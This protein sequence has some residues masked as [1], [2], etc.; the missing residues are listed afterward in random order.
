MTEPISLAPK[1]E[2]ALSMVSAGAAARPGL[3]MELLQDIA[4][5]LQ[6]LC[7]LI[8]GLTVAGLVIGE[9]TLPAT[10]RPMRIGAELL[11]WAATIAMFFVARGGRVRAGRLLA[12]GQTYEVVLALGISLLS[13]ELNW[14]EST[15]IGILWSPVAVWV[16][17]YPIVVPNTPRATFVASLLAAATEPL[18]AV[19]FA[20]FGDD[21]LPEATMFLRLVWPNVVAVVLAV[22]IS[23][24]VFGLGEQLKKARSMGSYHLAERLGAGGMGEVWKA[25]HRLLARTAAVKLIRPETLGRTD[26]KGV[27][28]A[29]RRF[30]REAQT[31][32]ALRS[33]HTVELYDFGVSRDGTLYYVMELLDGVDFQTLVDKHGPQPPQ[34]VV[35]LL[36][37]AC[38]SLYEAHQ[39]G[40][41]HRDIKPANIFVC[42]YGADLDFVKVLDFGIVKRA[43]LEE[44]DRREAQL[45][46]QGMITGTPAYIA[47]E[48]A[49]AEGPVDG[50][51]DLYSLGCV[52]YWLLSG[53]LVFDKSNPMAMVV[54]HSSETPKPLSQRTEL[55]VPEGLE[56][57]VMQCLA[58]DPADRP[59][60][61]RALSDMLGALEVAG[62]WTEDRKEDWWHKHGP[63]PTA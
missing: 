53:Q 18:V 41:V 37:Q 29:L 6:F 48:M 40:L 47:P 58:K 50:R 30:E 16:L 39:T 55:E 52:A 63:P 32:S 8:M 10:D 45:T 43:Q 20:L 24:I 38:H 15:R 34:R 25:T 4:R 60:N 27:A 2:D 35:H 7:L 42:R 46:A 26:D 1:T 13:V 9:L 61:A 56:R 49:M 57:I 11:I 62:Q 19:G 44:Q 33:P 54:A 12:L 23:K 28:T 14:F 3:P 59:Q 51:A 21:T 5:R 36:R 22:L 31:T 17:L